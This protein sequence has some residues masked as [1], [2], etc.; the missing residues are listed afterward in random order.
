MNH[1][2]PEVLSGGREGKIFKK[3]RQVIRPANPWTPHVQRFLQFL[4]EEGFQ[5][6]PQPYRINEKGQEVLSFVPGEVYNE[7]LPAFMLTDEILVEAAELLQAYHSASEKYISRLTRQEAWMLPVVA[8]IEV[9]CHGDFAPYN[10]TVVNG[11]L[12]G[13][14]DFDTAHPGPRL[15]D[16]A[17]A[18]YRWVPFRSP[19]NENNCHSLDE[20]ITRTR[21][22][23]NAYGMPDRERQRLPE[24]MAERLNSL[25]GYMKGQAEA[26]NEDFAK[27]IRDGHLNQYLE[28]IQYIKDNEASIIRGIR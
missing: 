2:R 6:I 23:L 8:P 14:I 18:V 24:M 9:M 13:M 26:G 10:V 12:F 15:W 27:N 21:I 28:D 1:D 5:N 11:R 3:G 17:Y 25:V 19:E 20:Q 16:A 4:L 7:P 22:F